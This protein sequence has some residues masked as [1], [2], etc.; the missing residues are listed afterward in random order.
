MFA[1]PAISERR[2]CAL[3]G[4]SRSVLHYVSR[5]AEHSSQ[6]RARLIELA[7]ERRRF[8]Y[9]RLHILVQRQ[10]IEANHKRFHR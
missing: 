10:G 2:A 4:I 9:R 6:L 1:S 7:A 3:V 8:G 5:E